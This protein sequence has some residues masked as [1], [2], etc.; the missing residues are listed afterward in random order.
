MVRYPCRACSGTGQTIGREQVKIAI[1][2]GVEDGQVLRVSVGGAGRSPYEPSQELFVT[3]RVE[4]SRHFRRDGADIHSDVN[5]SLAQ[6]ALGGKLRIPGIYE[7]V[8][9]TVRLQ[10]IASAFSFMHC[11]ISS[12]NCRYRQAPLVMTEFAFLERASVV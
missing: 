7:Q 3:V 5:I 12:L 9:V 11:L 8:L 4:A 10:S 1:P 6:A 2:P